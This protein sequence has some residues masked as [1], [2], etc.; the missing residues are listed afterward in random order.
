[1]GVVTRA[2]PLVLSIASV[3]RVEALADLHRSQ[4]CVGVLLRFEEMSGS[5]R[6]VGLATFPARSSEVLRLPP[7]DSAE[8]ASSIL[9]AG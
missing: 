2:Y 7:V 8:S 1:M 3:R 5:P 6:L 9:A 4:N